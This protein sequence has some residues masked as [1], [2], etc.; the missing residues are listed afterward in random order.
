MNQEWKQVYVSLSKECNCIALED[1]SQ[2]MEIFNHLSQLRDFA[3]ERTTGKF[4]H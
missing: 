3:K 1:C 2:L 4:Y